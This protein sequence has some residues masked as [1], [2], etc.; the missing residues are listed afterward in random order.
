VIHLD[1]SFLVDLLREQRKGQVGPA[2]TLLMEL[3]SEE[4]GISVHVACELFAGAELATDPRK[5]RRTVEAVCAGLRVAVPGEDFPPSYGKLLAH[6]R[7]SGAAIDTMD[8]LIATA[9]LRDE[10]PL[11]TRN[12]RHFSGIPG[13]DLIS[14]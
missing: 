13:L 6:L 12:T 1:T 14:Y 9:A 7:R 4:L 10:A 8:L 2:G 3:E 11:V 5:E